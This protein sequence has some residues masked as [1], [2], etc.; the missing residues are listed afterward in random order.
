MDILSDVLR[1]IRLKGAL[2]LNAEFGEPWCVN[3]PRGADFAPVLC[4]GAPSLAILHIVLEGRCRIRLADGT[5]LALRAG[6][7][8]VLPNGDAHLIGSGIGFAPVAL[9]DVVRVNLPELRRIR[10]GGP[11]ASCVL[12]CGWF[13]LERESRHPLVDALP[14]L[15]HCALAGRPAWAWLGASLHFAIDEAV[16]A[17]PGSAAIA[18]K[19]AE[20]LFFETLRG[21]ADSGAPGA[22]GWLAGLKDSAVAQ[23]LALMHR[24]PARSWSVESLAAQTHVSRSVLA[25]KFVQAVGMPPMQYLKKWRLATAARILSSERISVLRAAGAVGYESEASFSRAFKAQ[26]GVAPGSWRD[27]N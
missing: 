2:F 7:A 3:A 24:D 1:T 9:D 15:F 27:G 25:E 16:A 14:P 6:D 26:Y 8:A 12:V 13:A 20:S 18:T 17:T 23:C 22:A 19:V 5:E 10:Y 11:G 21:Y 4:P